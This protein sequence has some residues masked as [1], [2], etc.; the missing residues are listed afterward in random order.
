M[1]VPIDYNY[2]LS[3]DPGLASFG[4][5]VWRYPPDEEFGG[6]GTRLHHARTI[7]P[8]RA[9]SR[10]MPG[11]KAVHEAFAEWAVDWE[12]GEPYRH[13]VYESAQVYSHQVGN[14]SNVLQLAGALGAIATYKKMPPMGHLNRWHGYKPK[15]WT[16]QRPKQANWV[17]I[18]D[19][20]SDEER[21]KIVVETHADVPLIERAK[22]DASSRRDGVGVG[23]HDDAIMAIG[24]GLFH[25]HR[26]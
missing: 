14:E 18:L 26:L 2:A 8:D 15:V 20:L 16:K 6:D 13:V 19:R 7:E 9:S 17:R 23:K 5:A 21:S 3:I 22:N 4:V 12:F 1:V 10:W 11:F 25:T 24:V